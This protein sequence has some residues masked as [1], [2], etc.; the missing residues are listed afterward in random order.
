M[1]VQSPPT[2]ET[3]RAVFSL[4]N[5]AVAI[6]FVME[7]AGRKTPAAEI[8]SERLIVPE[9]GETTW[10]K[11]LGATAVQAG[12]VN[13]VRSTLDHTINGGDAVLHGS[14]WR[15]KLYVRPNADP[16]TVLD[17][18]KSESIPAVYGSR[19]PVK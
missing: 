9:R 16:D 2:P 19:P 1:S 18:L 15:M 3:E 14:H 6:N 11:V 17:W 4:S 5:W 8:S 10:F 12:S 7:E 13:S